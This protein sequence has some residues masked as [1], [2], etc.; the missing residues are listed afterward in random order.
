MAF[1]IFY[2]GSET[3]RVSDPKLQRLSSQWI[4]A[5]HGRH[6]F[7]A[8]GRIEELENVA[9]TLIDLPATGHAGISLIT[10]EAS[11]GT[12]CVDRS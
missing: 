4:E 5:I 3:Q 7:S 12:R 1:C 2:E 11:V 10:A 9:D 8:N 6:D